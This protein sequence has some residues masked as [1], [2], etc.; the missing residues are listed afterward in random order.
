MK[1]FIVCFILMV[2]IIF[3]LC[4][5]YPKI[6]TEYMEVPIEKEVLIEVPVE[7]IVEKEIIKEVPIETIVEKEVIVEVPVEVIVEVPVEVI[8]EKEVMM[9]PF[10]NFASWEDVL[11]WNVGDKIEHVT[12]VNGHLV[13]GYRIITDYNDDGTLWQYVQYDFIY[14]VKLYY[15]CKESLS[16]ERLGSYSVADLTGTIYSIRW[17]T[18]AYGNKSCIV[19]FGWEHTF[20]KLSSI[21]WE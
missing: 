19:D 8:V 9:M 20:I 6:V 10:Y 3:G 12:V 16:F 18:D 1:R 21:Q 2:S 17:E 5:C 13:S 7:V 14:P 4:A 15:G 11:T